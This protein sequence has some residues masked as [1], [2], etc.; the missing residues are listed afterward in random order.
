MP[1]IL[2]EVDGE[3]TIDGLLEDL[4]CKAEEILMDDFD[5][6]DVFKLANMVKDLYNVMRP[7]A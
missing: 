4:D 7:E 1:E 6:E 2:Y 3:K 5:E